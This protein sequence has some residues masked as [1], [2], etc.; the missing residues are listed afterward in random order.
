[1]LL[2]FLNCRGID[3]LDL[4]PLAGMPLKTL[5]CN[6]QPDRDAALLRSIKTLETINGKPAAEFWKEVDAKGRTGEGEKGR[7]GET[8]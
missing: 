1:M 5:Y 7:G 2:T 6:F 4:T 3:G 8:K